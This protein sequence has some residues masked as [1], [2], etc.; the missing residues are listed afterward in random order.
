MQLIGQ[1]RVPIPATK[2]H[3]ERIDYEYERKRRTGIFIFAESLSG[4]RRATARPRR[5]K[6]D[7][8]EEVTQQPDTRYAGV[9]RITLVCDNWEGMPRKRFTNRFRPARHATTCG[10]STSCIL[11]RIGVG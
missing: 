11:P 2:E 3:P 1:T 8:V 10:G 4:F 9:E 5:T 6:V 7:W